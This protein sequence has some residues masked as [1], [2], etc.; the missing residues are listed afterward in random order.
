MAAL[1]IEKNPPITYE[2]PN[3]SKGIKDWLNS[4]KQQSVQSFT[5]VSGPIQ[6]LN[7]IKFR[8]D[9]VAFYRCGQAFVMNSRIF[10]KIGVGAKSIDGCYFEFH[11]VFGN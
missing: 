11:V 8:N 9:L 2:D 4:G 1:I 3:I 7:K 10:T 6:S 5:G